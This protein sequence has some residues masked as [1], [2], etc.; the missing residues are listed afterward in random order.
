MRWMLARERAQPLAP[1]PCWRRL[2]TRGGAEL[3]VNTA[4]GEIARDSPPPVR[5]V[6]GGF[7]CD[8]PVRSC[9]LV[10]LRLRHQTRR[11]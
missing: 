8:E 9:A 5:A 4:T 7:F 1:H 6:R 3:H 2:R 11:A 10:G